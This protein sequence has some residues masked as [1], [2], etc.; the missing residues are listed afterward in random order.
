MAYQSPIYIDKCT[1]LFLHQPIYEEGE[2]DGAV[3]D[4]SSRIFVIQDPVYITIGQHVPP[5]TQEGFLIKTKENFVTAKAKEIIQPEG[6]G[7]GKGEPGVPP[8]IGEERYRWIEYH[9]HIPA[10]HIIEGH[11]SLSEIHYVFKKCADDD[12]SAA[13][14]ICSCA[15]ETK[16]ILVI[17]RTIKDH[18]IVQDLAKVQIKTPSKYFEYDGTLT[19]GLYSPVRWII[20]QNPIQFHVNDI[21]PVAK[22]SRPIQ[23]FDNRIILYCLNC[24]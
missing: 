15:Q 23:P 9:F 14:D 2:N 16:D 12:V 1:T 6:P 13:Y 10:E 19:T 3:F 7:G 4:A 22:S 5:G 11:H 20:G 21:V 8:T 24:A 17:G 18:N